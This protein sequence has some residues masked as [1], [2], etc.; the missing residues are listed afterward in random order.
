V[1]SLK[2]DPIRGSAVPLGNDGASDARAKITLVVSN[3][4]GPTAPID[5][6]PSL[7]PVARDAAFVEL[8]EKSFEH[9]WAV[10]AP[11]EPP[12]IKSGS[13]VDLPA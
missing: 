13:A 12:M 2:T 1:A 5:L 11:V 10:M 3:Q 9:L 4:V 6:L 8:P 7:K